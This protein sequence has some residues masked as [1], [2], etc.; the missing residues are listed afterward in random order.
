MKWKRQVATGAAKSV[1]LS[2]VLRQKFQINEMLGG[3]WE[4][5][6]WGLW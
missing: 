5:R 4:V 3:S 2:E 6:A 1:W